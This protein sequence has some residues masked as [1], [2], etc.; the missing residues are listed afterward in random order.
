ME[1]CDILI[2]AL[3]RFLQEEAEER[4]PDA[5]A[6]DSSAA[7]DRQPSALDLLAAMPVD[8]RE[9]SALDLLAATASER[10]SS[11]PATIAN[12]RQR[13][14][15]DSSATTANGRRR[16]T[17]SPS[18]AMPADD[19]QSSAP[20]SSAAIANNSQRS[21]PGSSATTTNDRPRSTSGSPATM[22]TNGRQRSAPSASDSSAAMSVDDEQPSGPNML[23]AMPAE[24]V[25]QVIPELD[26]VSLINLSQASHGFRDIIKPSR[27]DFVDRLLALECTEEYGGAET[28]IH[29]RVWRPPSE[30]HMH[31]SPERYPSAD[32]TKWETQR[33]ACGGCLKLLPHYQFDNRSIQHEPFR[34]PMFGTPS[35]DIPTTWKPNLRGTDRKH[36]SGLRRAQRKEL[37]LVESELPEGDPVL[38]QYTAAFKALGLDFKRELNSRLV[39][40]VDEFVVNAHGRPVTT[41]NPRTVTKM[42]T[43]I[44][45]RGQKRRNRR[46]IECLFQKQRDLCKAPPSIG[47]RTPPMKRSRHVRCGSALRRYFPGYS[48][49]YGRQSPPIPSL[50]MPS[51]VRF[52]RF[53]EMWK[54]VMIRCS[55][56]E[57]WQEMRAFRL[58]GSLLGCAFEISADS[59]E[60]MIEWDAEIMEQE[61]LGESVC[62]RCFANKHGTDLLKQVLFRWLSYEQSQELARIEALIKVGWISITDALTSSKFNS[63]PWSN[64]RRMHS[65][66]LKRIAPI[67][68][69]DYPLNFGSMT[70]LRSWYQVLFRKGTRDE[71]EIFADYFS[72]T[73]NWEFQWLMN[74]PLLQSHWFHLTDMIEVVQADKDRLVNWALDPSLGLPLHRKDERSLNNKRNKGP[75]NPPC[76]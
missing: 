26:P 71:A 1:N 46:C 29:R 22:P 24:L 49:I 6:P 21:A 8:G 53:Q 75:R 51:F 13:P 43:E 37:R 60:G 41:V 66:S 39:R 16:S 14:P 30:M 36:I 61:S 68:R 72:P 4:Q 76:L 12:N 20:G 33:F 62:N 44:S 9:R 55:G 57:V 40:G 47:D 19:T 2:Q 52:V 70:L 7:D 23:S 5:P 42:L 50:R 31:Y 25:H 58:S 38:L 32:D 27:E 69:R 73:R 67:L 65:I 18:A 11:A 35:A 17:C 64:L 63:E 56:C 74:F 10:R 45:R 15:P 3:E 54:M 48:E 59:W 34:K 28:F